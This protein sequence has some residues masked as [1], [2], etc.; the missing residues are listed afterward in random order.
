MA[1]ARGKGQI[2]GLP[3]H[4]QVGPSLVQVEVLDR[5]GMELTGKDDYILE[6]TREDEAFRLTIKWMRINSPE[7]TS[8]ETQNGRIVLPTKV[9]LRLHELYERLT[10]RSLADRARRAQFTRK[11]MGIVPFQKKEAQP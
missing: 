10:A 11:A 2:K 5:K 4:F 8:G 6:L 9:V 3:G 1:N 7:P